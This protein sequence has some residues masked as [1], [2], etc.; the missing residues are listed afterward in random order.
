MINI[1]F[2]RQER[3]GILYVS[4][5]ITLSIFFNSLNIYKSNENIDFS[6][7]KK[8]ISLFEKEQLITSK[9][10]MTFLHKKSTQ[11]YYKKKTHYNSIVKHHK[12][13]PNQLIIN[14]WLS[15]GFSEK[16][17]K[18]I[19]NYIKSNNGIKNKNDLKKIYV[20]NEQKFLS[21]IKYIDIPTTYQ[22]KI[23][24]SKIEINTANKEELITINGIG[25]VIAKRIIKYRNILGGFFSLNQ[26]KEVYG[27]NENNFNKIITELKIDTSKIEKININ[28]ANKQE[29]TKN[30]Y[31]NYN[32]AKKIISYK[33]NNGSFNNIDILFSKNIITNNKLKYYL[34]IY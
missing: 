5:I 31:I 14:D 23:Q 17:S 26:L 32:L 8:R 4:L 19:L 20:I 1:S 24:K 11:K 27:I 6:N 21:I 29:L 18:V 16:Q 7:F 15:L 34:T 22:K 13:N 28:F 9:N 3:R 30:P 2:S 12:F 33:I 25:E 10:K